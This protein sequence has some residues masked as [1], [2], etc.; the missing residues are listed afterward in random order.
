MAESDRM[1]S[2]I[3]SYV[4]K[5]G[6]VE[7]ENDLHNGTMTVVFK[8]GV[9][10]EGR[11]VDLRI[12]G[13]RNVEVS[14]Y[15]PPEWRNFRRIAQIYADALSLIDCFHLIDVEP[16]GPDESQSGQGRGLRIAGTAPR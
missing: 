9:P 7:L 13:T 3:S 6:N 14:L 10:S 5:Y 11:V 4:A 16:V 2:A 12:H 1:F 8:S 15:A